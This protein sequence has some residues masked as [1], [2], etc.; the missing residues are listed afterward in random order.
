MSGPK[1]KVAAVVITG[2]LASFKT[3]ATPGSPM[4][5][6]QWARVLF[7]FVLD[8]SRVIPGPGNRAALRP[9]HRPLAATPHR[10]RGRPAP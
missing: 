8:R 6:W 5:P 4:M 3:V 2:P 7:S 1:S 10:D 9:E